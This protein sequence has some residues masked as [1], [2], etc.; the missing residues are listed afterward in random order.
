MPRAVA[1]ISGVSPTLDELGLKAVVC[2]RPPAVLGLVLSH[3][4]LGFL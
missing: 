3:T 1:V 2:G 4:H